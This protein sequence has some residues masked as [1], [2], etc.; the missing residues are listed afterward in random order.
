MMTETRGLLELE[1]VKELSRASKS[2]GLD[3][4]SP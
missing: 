4:V 2:N 1:K 3:D